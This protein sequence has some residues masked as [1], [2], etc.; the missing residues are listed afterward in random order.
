VGHFYFPCS[1][2]DNSLSNPMKYCKSIL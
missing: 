2:C 1:G